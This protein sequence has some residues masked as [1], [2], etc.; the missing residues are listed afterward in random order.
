MVFVQGEFS[1]P[2]HPPKGS[3][4]FVDLS[5]GHDGRTVDFPATVKE[6]DYSLVDGVLK[7]EIGIEEC[8]VRKSET[9][10]HEQTLE[11]ILKEYEKEIVPELRKQGFEVNDGPFIDPNPMP[12]ESSQKGN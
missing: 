9:G 5:G 4:I 1:C 12:Q 7:P 3:R 10:S 2:T 6:S 11:K 8:F